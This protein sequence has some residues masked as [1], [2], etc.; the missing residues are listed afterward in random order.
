MIAP[1]A[2][3][4]LVLA[5]CVMDPGSPS[6]PNNGESSTPSATAMPTPSVAAEDPLDPSTW[7]I[8]ADGIG[9]ARLG[10]PV[11]EIVARLTEFRVPAD[12]ASSCFNT[13]ITY[14]AAP[15]GSV[16]TAPLLL[17]ANPDGTLGAV[18]FI[19]PGPHS[20][21]GIDVGSSLTDA[22]AAYPTATDEKRAT[23]TPNLL[24]VRGTPGWISYE[25]DGGPTQ[26]TQVQ[27]IT[28]GLPPSEYCG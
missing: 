19:A 8:S 15:G 13:A 28:G 7:L 24:T 18:A 4:L 12:A 1:A 6:D 25:Y 20:A 21:S 3:A 14:L 10:Q 5:G 22:R 26:I 17:A 16:S 27:V 2:A 11:A 9:P 23:D